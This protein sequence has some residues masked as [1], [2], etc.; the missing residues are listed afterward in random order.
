MS[1]TTESTKFEN[2][3]S[4]KIKMMVLFAQGVKIDIFVDNQIYQ[5][6]FAQFT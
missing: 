3:K 4:A 2:V 6:A 1:E 5:M